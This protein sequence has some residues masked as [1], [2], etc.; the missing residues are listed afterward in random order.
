[1]R[2]SPCLAPHKPEPSALRDGAAT[3]TRN[4]AAMVQTYCATAESI[5]AQAT[6]QDHAN[7]TP[8]RRAPS[9]ARDGRD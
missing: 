1:V 6:P 5:P 4:A 3:P 7:P 8:S 9:Q 2:D